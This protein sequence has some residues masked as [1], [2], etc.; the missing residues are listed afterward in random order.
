[1]GKVKI[2]VEHNKEILY[3]EVTTQQT[4]EICMLYERLYNKT[5]GIEGCN[6]KKYV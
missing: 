6:R 1:M 3:N 2:K 4:K 5:A